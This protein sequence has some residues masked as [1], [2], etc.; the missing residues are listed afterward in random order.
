MNSLP[1]LK[2]GDQL[3][4][5]LRGQVD[6]KEA[7]VIKVGRRWA[8]IRILGYY[9]PCRINME[10]GYAD[11]NSYSGR[12]Y[13]SEVIYEEHLTLRAEWDELWRRVYQVSGGMRTIPDHLTLADIQQVKQ[14]LEEKKK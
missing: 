4:F 10:T 13:T 6:G 14:I 12:C 2:V 9:L 11:G 5:I 3:W 8:T 7:V 1:K